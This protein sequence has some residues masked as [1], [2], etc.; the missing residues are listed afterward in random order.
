MS[1]DVALRWDS[2]TF[3]VQRK[4][5]NFVQYL[6][7]NLP[8]N[9]YGVPLKL[10]NPVLVMPYVMEYEQTSDLPDRVLDEATME[11]VIDDGLPLVEGVPIWERF[12][13]EPVEYYKVFK[14]YRELLYLSGSRTIAKVAQMVDVAIAHLQTLSKTFHWQLRCKA[15]DLYKAQE[16][17]RKRQFDIEKLEGKHYQAAEKLLEQSLTYF[18]QHP[19]QMNPKIALQM[20]QTA[21]KMGRLSLGL[22]PDKP[23]VGNEGSQIT[24]N[25]LNG[26][27]SSD[28]MGEGSNP[29]NALQTDDFQSILNILV[30]SGALEQA[31]SQVVDADYTIVE[32]TSEPAGSQ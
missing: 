7:V 11:V 26:S 10:I 25:Q 13:G 16:R 9:G 23:G 31:Q 21:V 18:E 32:E 6:Q 28:K 12:D 5:G 1:T 27:G 15:Y 17:E 30:K 20:M 8:T 3:A 19:E 24:I 4:L 29:D 22:S 2:G 14:T